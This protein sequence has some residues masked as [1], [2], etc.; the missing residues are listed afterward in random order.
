MRRAVVLAALLL[1]LVPSVAAADGGPVTARSEVD[2]TTMTIGDQVLLTVTVDLAKGY[3]LLSPG[4][5]RAI[6]DFEVVDVLTVLQTRLTD[7]STR[8]QLRYVLTT[9]DLGQKQVPQIVVGY[10]D[11]N[12]QAGQAPTQGP[13]VIAV[14]SVIAPGE[15]VSDIKPLKPP[16]P[17]PVAQGDL[18]ARA[19]PFAA[20][21][22][23][24]VLIAALA[25][26]VARRRRI[27]LD[28]VG[29]TRA[30]REAL[31]ELERVAELRLPEQGRTLEHYDLV[32][33]ALRRFLGRR[34]GVVA[35]ARTARELRR[36]LERASVPRAQVELLCEVLGD[37]ESVRYEERSIFP[38][39]AQ[40]TMRE[41]IESMRKS[42]V[43][44]E[45]ELVRGG[46]TA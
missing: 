20:V 45:Y 29:V 11:A 33:A 43:A 24:L 34:Y 28:E 4:V 41:L 17:M 1:A 44:E 8:V 40:K 23:L 35:D 15:D 32:S 31:D 12:G 39:R 36:D 26:R 22:L 13:L 9:F 7:G 27:A 42:V 3:D 10:R 19:A 18:L 30:A 38:A 37:A 14:K 5:P 46:A 2:R 6:G 16:L 21:A 25:L